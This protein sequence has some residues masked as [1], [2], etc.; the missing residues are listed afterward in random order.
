MLI[1]KLFID[2][3]INQRKKLNQISP[4]KL[5]LFQLEKI[6]PMSENKNEEKI[7]YLGGGKICLIILSQLL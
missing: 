2:M 4:P 6:R 1:K 3:T 7:K 5:L